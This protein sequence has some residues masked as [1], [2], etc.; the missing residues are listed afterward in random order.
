M[1]ELELSTKEIEFAIPRKEVSY[2]LAL[3]CTTREDGY[4]WAENRI[5]EK[6]MRLNNILKITSSVERVLSELK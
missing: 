6:R 4:L 5:I 1:K 3:S 2:P